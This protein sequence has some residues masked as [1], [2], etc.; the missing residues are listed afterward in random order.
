[1]ALPAQRVLPP[2]ST[3]NK[4]TSTNEN[5]GAAAASIATAKENNG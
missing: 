1:M 4:K 5:H 2:S 3:L